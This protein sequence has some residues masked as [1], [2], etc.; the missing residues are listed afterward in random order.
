MKQLQ[1]QLQIH[2]HIHTDIHTHPQSHTH[3]YTKHTIVVHTKYKEALRKNPI[4]FKQT[5]P[6]ER[7]QKAGLK[8]PQGLGTYM[9]FNYR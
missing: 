9:C 1:I 6:L 8:L 3:R 5:L 7:Y 4:F 2:T